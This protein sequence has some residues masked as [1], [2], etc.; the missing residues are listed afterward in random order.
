MCELKVD[1]SPTDSPPIVGLYKGYCGAELQWGSCT[2]AGQLYSP[3]TMTEIDR[4]FK[5]D[6][7]IWEY[8]VPHPA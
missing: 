1:Y 5:D 2:W 8:P 7:Y 3:Q 4:N 6:S